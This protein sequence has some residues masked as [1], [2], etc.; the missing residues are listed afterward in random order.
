SYPMVLKMPEGSFS[1]GVFKATTRS[2]LVERLDRLFETSALVLAQEYLFTDY[3]WRIGVLNGRAIFACK[4]RMARNHW[5]IYNH[6]S[7]RYFSGGFETLPTFEVPKVVLDAAIKACKIIGNGLYGV[8]IKEV[9]G[10]AYVIEVNDNPS[11]DYK[12][13]DAYLGDELYMQVMAEFCRRLEL[14]GR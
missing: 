1:N 13:E 8:D 11:M 3:D 4:Y 9:D 6:N 14:R 12:V 7:K 5:Q 10:R 2:E